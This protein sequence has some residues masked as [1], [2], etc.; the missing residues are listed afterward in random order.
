MGTLIQCTTNI[1]SDKCHSCTNLK[2]IYKRQGQSGVAILVVYCFFFGNHKSLCALYSCSFLPEND[3]Q[4]W[5]A[6]DI[7]QHNP[8]RLSW[9]LLGTDSV[10]SAG[11]QQYS[12]RKTDSAENQNYRP[13]SLHLNPL[14]HQHSDHDSWA[15]HD[16]QVELLFPT[17]FWLMIAKSLPPKEMLWRSFL[18]RNK[19]LKTAQKVKTIFTNLKIGEE[20]CSSRQFDICSVEL[21]VLG[22]PARD[23]VQWIGVELMT[24]KHCRFLR[25]MLHQNPLCDSNLEAKFSAAFRLRSHV[26]LDLHNIELVVQNSSWHANCRGFSITTRFSAVPSLFLFKPAIVERPSRENVQPMMLFSVHAIWTSERLCVLLNLGCVGGFGRQ[27]A[28]VV[29]LSLKSVCSGVVSESTVGEDTHG[30]ERVGSGVPAEQ[31]ATR[32]THAAAGNGPRCRLQRR[33]R[34]W[35]SASPSTQLSRENHSKCLLSNSSPASR[36]KLTHFIHKTN[37]SI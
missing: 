15:S 6:C 3:T 22:G 23:A 4:P 35:T 37:C 12:L 17:P 16:S 34:L 32:G 21:Q 5:D 24:C 7:L 36:K 9:P 18:L 28:N 25:R 30:Q 31:E 11:Q 2:K 19:H 1:S 10:V 27:T 14:E 33:R 26:D 8:P 20:N 13:N 29:T